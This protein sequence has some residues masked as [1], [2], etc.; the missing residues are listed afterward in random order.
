MLIAGCGYL[1][2]RIAARARQRGEDVVCLVRTAQSVQRLSTAGFAAYP[3]DLDGD[4][5]VVEEARQQDRVFYFAPPPP[6]GT[7]DSRIARFL[8]A[9][10]GRPRRVVYVSTTGVYGNCLGEWVDETRPPNPQ[11]DRALRRFDAEQRLLHWREASGGEVV[12]LRVAGIYGPGKL[13]LQ[14]LR[15]RVP[16]IAAADAPWTNRVHIDDLVRVAEAAMLQGGDGEVY[17]VSDGNPGN[18]RDYF[19]RVADAFA[20]PRAPVVTLAD[21]GDRLSPGMLSYLAESRRLDN[22]KMLDAFGLE[23]DYPDLATGL[24]ACVEAMQAGTDA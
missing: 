10:D 19:D 7:V 17:N 13:P 15:D 16:M 3:L 23:L 6:R 12:I 4:I 1:G 21:A 5:V 8:D 18:M 20:L 14:R 24:Q 9:L 22:R 2:Q 11:V